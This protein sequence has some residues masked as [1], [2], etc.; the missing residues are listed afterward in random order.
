MR[1][2]SR[3]EIQRAPKIATAEGQRR[4]AAHGSGKDFFNILADSLI[5]EDQD[6][7]G[8]YFGQYPFVNRI[9]GR[10]KHL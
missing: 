9:N 7:E 6:I 10:D 2:V 5:D 4:R 1:S 8:D 3:K